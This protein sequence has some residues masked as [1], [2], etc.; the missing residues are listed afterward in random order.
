MR[1]PTTSPR[2]TSRSHTSRRGTSIELRCPEGLQALCEWGQA[3]SHQLQ[4]RENSARQSE[5]AV[6]KSPQGFLAFLKQH[7]KLDIQDALRLLYS[8]YCA[9]ENIEDLYRR[10][11]CSLAAE[12]VRQGALPKLLRWAEQY[13]LDPER[14]YPDKDDALRLAMNDVPSSLLPEALRP[15]PVGTKAVSLSRSV[16]SVRSEVRVTRDEVTL[17]RRGRPCCHQAFFHVVNI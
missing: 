2:N 7:T 17:E 5:T 15:L 12:Q 11:L 3:K 4:G 10:Y 14:F 6:N 1:M 9:Q 16:A 8:D 13:F